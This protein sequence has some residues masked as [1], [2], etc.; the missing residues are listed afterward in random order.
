MDD[1]R[2]PLTL[3]NSYKTDA[4]TPCKATRRA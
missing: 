1:K 4:R 3:L 2:G